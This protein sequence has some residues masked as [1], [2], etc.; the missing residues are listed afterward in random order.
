MERL[1]SEPLN[2]LVR[3]GRSIARGWNQFFFQPADPT[4]LGLIRVVTGLLA[5]WNLW[6]YG[7][8]LDVFLADSGWL[9][10]EAVRSLQPPGAD[11][12]WSF[13]FGVPDAWLRTVWVGCLVV[14]AMMTL[15]LFSRVTTLLT[16]IIVV[17]TVRRVPGLMFGF[18][19]MLSTLC[20]YLAVSMAS[21]QAVSL[22]RLIAR[23]R[24]GRRLLAQRIGGKIA[25]WPLPGGVPTPTV[26]ANLGLR[27]I[28]LHLCV[29]YGMAG[30]SKLQGGMW[31]TGTA[32]WPTWIDRE[33]N[34]FDFTWLA[35]HIWLINLA[36]HA[37]ILS[38][39][40]YPFLIWNRPIRPL[41]LVTV[42]VM[43]V[44]IGVTLGLTEF[45]LAM[46]AM[47][48]A[49]LSGPWL[50]SLV[51]GLPERQPLYRVLYDGA[52]PKCRAGMA[53]V[54]A[55]DPAHV[56][57]PIDLTAVNPATVHP[58]L[59]PERC[60]GAMQ[61]VRRDGRIFSGWDG[62]VKLAAI[63][64]LAWPLA[65]IG[66]LPVIA[67]MG[68]RW[69]NR[70][71]ATRPR[72]ETGAEIPCADDVCGLPTPNANANA[73]ANRPLSSRPPKATAQS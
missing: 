10:K 27:L 20:L 25:T 23:W 55:C 13:W 16:W 36:T 32:V 38:E 17:S 63:Q 19:Q 28:Q 57:Q 53:F 15:G 69:Y 3:L 42:A 26:S 22:D 11:W 52:C 43:H 40:A 50:R 12:S 56:V 39:I 4:P 6:V 46:I 2:Y 8:E 29:I 67:P 71:A 62:V 37:T 24:A 51:A 34:A 72:D 59:T 44:G 41:L 45:A 5:F 65:W 18:D 47:N 70:Y 68:R 31:W 58:E 49:F 21:G 9:S 60:R 33:F 30:I 61:V 48:F 14:T 66:R 7:L 35:D 73:N 1:L 64:P 54:S